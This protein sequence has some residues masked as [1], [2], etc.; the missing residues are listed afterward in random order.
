MISK[1]GVRPTP[2]YRRLSRDCSA[3][4]RHPEPVHEGLT[5]NGCYLVLDFWWEPESS[6]PL[7]RLRGR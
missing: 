3:A 6:A 5:G 7:S 1:L 2:G 4:T